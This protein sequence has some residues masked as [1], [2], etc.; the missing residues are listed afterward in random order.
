MRVLITGCCGFVGSELVVYL[1]ESSGLT[2]FE[3]IGIDNLSR[4]GSWCNLDR[5]RSLGVHVLDGDLRS[6]LDLETIGSIDWVID[7]AS[8]PSV[9]A[10]VD[11]NASSRRLIEHNLLGTVNI[12]ELFNRREAG[13]IMLSTSRVYS[14]A[15]FS[16]LPVRVLIGAYAPEFSAIDLDGPFFGGRHL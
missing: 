3:I 15:A 2:C 13:M 8:N 11:G 14:I 7:A 12:L 5:L 10:G 4:R 6:A 16:S 9:L 1:L